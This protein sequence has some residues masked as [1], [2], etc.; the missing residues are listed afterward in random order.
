MNTKSKTINNKRIWRIYKIIAI[1][2]LT[3]LLIGDISNA[4]TDENF[5]E[6]VIIS[7]QGK[8]DNRLVD[9]LEILKNEEKIDVIVRLYSE[10]ATKQKLLGKDKNDIID[11]TKPV[12]FTSLTKSEIN[13]LEKKDYIISIELP[14]NIASQTILATAPP[15]TTS[16]YMKTV[17]PVTTYD[18]GC[19]LGKH[20]KDTSGTQDNVVILMFGQ[21]YKIGTAY[22]AYVYGSPATTTSIGNAVKQ[23][24]KAYYQC[25][26]SD[27]YSTVQIAV[28]TSNYGSYVTYEHGKAWA[29]MVNDIGIYLSQ[30]GYNSQS[31]VSG[32]SDMELSW[33]N[34][35]ITKNWIKGYASANNYPLFDFGDAAGCPQYSPTGP[36]QNGNC[37]NGWKQ[38]DVWYKA[39]GADPSYPFP[40]QYN[41]AGAQAR[42]WY[43]ISLY[44]YFNKG[45]RINILGSLTQFGACKTRNCVAGVKNTP[46][47]GWSQLYNV[48]NSDTR[49][50]QNL[51]WSTD[52]KWQPKISSIYPTSTIPKTFDLTIYGS[53]FDD[54]II[55]EIY[56]KADGHYVGRTPIALISKCVYPCS[57]VKIVAREYMTG[58]T[59]G[60]YV[61]RV[62]NSE[63]GLSN[64]KNL[65]LI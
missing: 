51:R 16:Y 29:Q 50:A 20:D 44:S 61:V 6:K 54:G 15:Y 22:G 31:R 43:R 57:P 17:D 37:N 52:I 46:E 38:E 65:N 27:S 63:G 10:I 4:A 55:E 62:R 8:L 25:T 18:M 9:K 34:S 59:K 48:L 64:G 19:K 1:S 21:P 45:G 33:K 36:N 23:F 7:K 56:W 42:Q 49:T 47:T 26:G 40:Q 28:G 24:G 32:A 60:T 13:E 41:T 58:A 12:V 14:N 5:D 3:L 11:V 39:W 35:T 2:M 53:D 30:N